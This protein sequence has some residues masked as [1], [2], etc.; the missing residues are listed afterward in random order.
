LL[1]VCVHPVTQELLVE[2]PLT[3]LKPSL[4]QLST[5]KRKF[6]RGAF[7]EG[8]QLVGAIGRYQPPEHVGDPPPAAGSSGIASALAR[9]PAGTAA[10]LAAAAAMADLVAKDLAKLGLPGVNGAA[11]AAAGASGSGAGRKKASKVVGSAALGAAGMAAAAT[12]LKD[13]ALAAA[14]TGERPGYLPFAGPSYTISPWGAG[15]LGSGS[16]APG[17]QLAFATQDDLAGLPL[18]SSAGISLATGA[19]GTQAPFPTSDLSLGLGGYGGDM[20]QGGLG[21][22]GFG[23]GVGGMGLAGVGDT[24]GP[25]SQAFSQSDASDLFHLSGLGTQG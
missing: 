17:S 15:R 11:A 4:I 16:S 24:Q 14:E 12:T 10:G 6:D 25:L 13:S 20:S 8:A 23:G 2:G 18:G 9:N 5:P 7:G 22:G 1:P 3:N 21:F 19:M